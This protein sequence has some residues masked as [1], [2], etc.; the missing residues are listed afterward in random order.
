VSSSYKYKVTISGKTGEEEEST[1][2]QDSLE[3]R[4][5][6]ADPTLEAAELARP[7]MAEFFSTIE[8][9]GDKT[10]Y[11]LAKLPEIVGTGYAYA[12]DVSVVV[13]TTRENEV[14]SSPVSGIFL[15]KPLA[16]TNLRLDKD[17]P[18]GILFH[19]SMTPYVQRYKVKWR[20]LDETDGGAEVVEA[21]VG[22][23]S[24][25]DAAETSTISFIFPP[26]LVVGAVYKVNVFSVVDSNN[27]TMDS[28]ELHE[29]FLLKSEDELVVY[30]EEP[31][32]S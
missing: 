16:P 20:P 31:K 28:K 18:R 29:K 5:E 14:T 7:K 21:F 25:H 4:I 23:T 22:A 24:L 6:A 27:M 17:R 3:W 15:T 10:Q 9:P 32:E 30:V 1:D 26:T 13:T 2:E 11:T 19:K 8:V 12:I